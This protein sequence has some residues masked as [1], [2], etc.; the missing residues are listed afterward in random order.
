MR[1]AANR[2]SGFALA[3]TLVLMALIV[4]VVVAYLVS[5]RIERSTSSA[6]ANR[7]RAKI[8]AESG[9]AAAI[10][11]LKDNTRYGN[12]ITAM[13]APSPSPASIYTEIY[14]PAD[15]TDPNHGVKAD[16]YL[17]LDNAAGDILVSRAT[18]SSSPG[19][20]ARPTPEV[21]STPLASASPFAVTAPNFSPASSYDFNQTISVGAKTGRLVQPSPSPAYGQWINVRDTSNQVVGRYAF[22]I[23]DESMKINV[24]FA[25]NASGTRNN[26]LTL[27]GPSSVT[28][29][30]QEMD[31]GAILPMVTPTPNRILADTTLAA[32][33]STGG[34]LSSRSTL[35]LL[36]EWKNT[37]PDYVHMVTTLSKDDNTTARG[38]QRL[39]VNALAQGLTTN[40]AK[41]AAATRIA[42]WIRDAWT[43]PGAAPTPI[44]TLSPAQ[45]FNDSRLRQQIAANIVDYIAPAGPSTDMSPP[46]TPAPSPTASPAPVIG[47]VK[48]PYIHAIEIIFQAANTDPVAHTTTVQMKL[49]F[50]FLNMFETNLDLD[51]QIG[52]IQ[53]RGLPTLTKNGASLIDTSGNFT[54]IVSPTIAPSPSSSLSPVTGSGLTVTKGA[55]GTSSSGV[56]SF[57]TGWMRS[58]TGPYTVPATGTDDRPRFGGGTLYV[59]VFGKNGERLDVIAVTLTPAN[60]LTGYYY[61]GSSS[62]GD[63]VEDA[64]PTHGATQIA[65]ISLSDHIAGSANTGPY[66]DPRYRPA[67]LTDRWDN[68]SR[69]DATCTSLT[70]CP[71]LSGKTVKT[72]RITGFIDIAEV[73]CRSYAVDWYDYA[74]DRPFTFIRNGPMLNIGELGNIAACEYPWRSIYLQHPER[75]VNTADTPWVTE[76]PARRSQSLDYVLIDLFRAG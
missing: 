15:A 59:T 63:F 13:P 9:L 2:E 46:P 26:D 31:P 1:K 5:T 3:L 68:D 35:G 33:G 50:R 65:S 71:W 16:D 60:K 12:Y 66:G 14:R 24:N 57:A 20:D 6:N 51:D 28:D 61:N 37:F 34:R 52:S 76:V 42:N 25:G 56:K 73:N 4:V 45:M 27:P 29:Q 11:L 74:G 22:F 18:A 39:D 64:I 38:W 69:T 40:T 53:V 43:G 10:H 72:N 36:T 8:T 44:A 48:I 23:E 21:I 19:P 55:D 54:A 30:I 47:I 67:T 41:V 70:D 49:Q 17:R 7:V 75:P 58:T 62:Q 32:L